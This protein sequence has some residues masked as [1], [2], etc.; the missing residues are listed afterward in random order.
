MRYVEEMTTA[1][2]D[3][4]L[5]WSPQSAL[6]QAF[7]ASPHL[8]TGL[9]NPPVTNIKANHVTNI[10]QFHLLRSCIANNLIKLNEK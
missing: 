2:K 10:Q 4:F 7:I 5:K 1:V 6:A 3:L 8:L 9:Y